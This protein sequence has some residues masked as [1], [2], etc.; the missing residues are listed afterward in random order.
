MRCSGNSFACA[1][2]ECERAGE[3]RKP[4]I[5]AVIGCSARGGFWREVVVE[6]VAS[7]GAGCGVLVGMGGYTTTIV[8][9]TGWEQRVMASMLDTSNE[10]RSKTSTRRTAPR[11]R[12][13]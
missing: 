12:V 8:S 10:T 3:V 7:A 11:S 6:A 2:F 5:G 4:C 13:P 9:S 1:A